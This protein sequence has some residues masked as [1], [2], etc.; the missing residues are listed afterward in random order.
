MGICDSVSHGHCLG[1]GAW[2]GVERASAHQHSISIGPSATVK[3]GV[4][5]SENEAEPELHCVSQEAGG[6][7]DKSKSV[8]LCT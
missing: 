5:N 1:E 6:V 7:E 8:Q 3:L 4:L 2:P